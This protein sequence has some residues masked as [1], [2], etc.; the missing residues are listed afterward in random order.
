M[1][2]ELQ[3]NT[4]PGSFLLR[5]KDLSF[6]IFISTD[7]LRCYVCHELNHIARKC[8]NKEKLPTQNAQQEIIEENNLAQTTS[9]LNTTIRHIPMTT[10]QNTNV[11]ENNIEISKK[12]THLTFN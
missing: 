10:S 5:Y 11:E 4:L 6:G 2:V 12:N 9:A 7:V 1:Y 8:P 3:E